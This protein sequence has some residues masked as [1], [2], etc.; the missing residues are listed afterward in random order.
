M[1]KRLR[2]LAWV[3]AFLVVVAGIVFGVPASRYTAL[4]YLRHE[5]ILDDYYPSGYY[6]HA[7]ESPDAEARKNAAFTLGKLGAE[8]GPAVPALSRALADHDDLVRLNAALALFK[9]GPASRPAVPALAIALN[10]RVQLVRMDAALTL[11]RIGPDAREAVPELIASL[12]R[13]EN[14]ERLPIFARTVREQAAFALGRIG[15]D[16]RD[17][18]PA[19]RAAL[20]DEKGPMR[21]A[22][23][24]ALRR[25]DPQSQPDADTTGR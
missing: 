11:T 2:F 9:I 8:G 14:R 18:V 20:A 21:D 4:G 23:E 15:P 19:L 1:G 25:I 13:P 10:D 24:Q 22:A 16:A 12:G 6:V 3:V 17:A 7:L 5:P